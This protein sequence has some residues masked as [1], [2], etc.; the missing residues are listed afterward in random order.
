MSRR[1]FYFKYSDLI[2]LN[3]NGNVSLPPLSEIFLVSRVY[4]IKIY[5]KLKTLLLLDFIVRGK[6]KLF[7]W[8][9]QHAIPLAKLLEIMCLICCI[10]MDWYIFPDNMNNL[11]D[12]FAQLIEIDWCKSKTNPMSANRLVAQILCNI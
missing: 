12:Q 7:E 11:I 2:E 1:I 3:W 8:T 6:K 9:R 10:E 4:I 5:H